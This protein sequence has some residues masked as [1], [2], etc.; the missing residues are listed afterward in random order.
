MRAKKGEGLLARLGRRDTVG[1]L[2]CMLAFAAVLVSSSLYAREIETAARAIAGMPASVGSLVLALGYLVLALVGYFRPSTLVRRGARLGA[3]GGV[4]LLGVLAPVALLLGEPAALAATAVLYQLVEAWLT[5]LVGCRLMGLGSL[6]AAAVAVVGGVVLRQLALA[7]YGLPLGEVGWAVV[8]GVLC[9]GSAAYLTRSDAPL[10]SSLASRESLDVLEL[11]NPLASLRPPNA[12][13][14][15]VALV[16][17][18]YGF[19]C[20]WGTPEFGALRLTVVLLLLALLWLLLVRRDGQEDQLFSLAVFFIMAGLLAVPLEPQLGVY[21]A[22]SLLFVGSNCFD[23]LLWLLIYG[24]GRRNPVAMVPVFGAVNCLSELGFVAGREL[25]GAVLAMADERPG[26][27]LVVALGLALFFFSFVWF[28]FK[29][30]SFAEAIRGVELLERLEVGDGAQG[31]GMPSFAER[32]DGTARAAGLT[33]R[34][35][36]VFG[37]LARGRNARYIMDVLGVTRNTAKAHIA[38]IYAKLGVHS[39]QELLSMVDGPD[40]P[41]EPP[42]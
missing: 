3:L 37:L 26:G 28:A 40:A 6:K 41:G 27:G 12:L 39:H 33:P 34:E 8:T 14:V 32:L 20:T 11:T 17:L 21:A 19:S 29:R 30:F 18:T 9:I 25:G 35:A 42:V 23:I 7:A 36:E 15:C 5:F 38:H 10:L 2:G 31:E 16:S 24:L 13:F 4:V 22:N 1:A